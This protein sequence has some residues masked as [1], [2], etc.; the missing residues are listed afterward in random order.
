ME[1]EHKRST[2]LIRMLD[3]TSINDLELA[4]YFRLGVVKHEKHEGI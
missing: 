4:E 1:T 2:L 3:I